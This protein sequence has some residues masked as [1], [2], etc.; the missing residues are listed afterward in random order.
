MHWYLLV[1]AWLWVCYTDWRYRRIDNWVVVYLALA[2][3][4]MLYLS[5]S[6]AMPVLKHSAAV[7]AAGYL[8]WRLN[9]VGAGDVKLFFALSLWHL[10]EMA[11]FILC[12]SLIGGMIALGYLMLRALRRRRGE[13]FDGGVPYGI[14]IVFASI[15]LHA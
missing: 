1:P 5:G 14:A 6:A 8:A 9:L 13:N 10:E 3:L 2:G 11:A 15:A 4:I 7:L 12:M